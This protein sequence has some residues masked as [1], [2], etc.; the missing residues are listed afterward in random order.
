MP[1]LKRYNRETQRWEPINQ[2][3]A[4]GIFTD[5]PILTTEEQTTRSV[6]DVLLQNRKELD[7]LRKNVSWLAIHMNAGN[8]DG[9]G[10]CDCDPHEPLSLDEVQD[11][12]DNDFFNE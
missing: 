4:A 6:E 10:S 2:V 1:V 7:L 9:N 3:P 5:N 12:F 11:V 8:G